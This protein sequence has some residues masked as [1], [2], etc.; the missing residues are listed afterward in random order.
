VKDETF[1]HQTPTNC[2]A[3]RDFPQTSIYLLN[4][5]I[6]GMR[7]VSSVSSFNTENFA[8]VLSHIKLASNR[9]LYSVI[10]LQLNLPVH[11]EESRNPDL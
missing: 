11:R 8:G 7:N 3:A 9:N 5:A 6:C 4:K 10:N 2:S 1:P